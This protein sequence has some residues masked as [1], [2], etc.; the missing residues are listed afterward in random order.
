M[1]DIGHNSFAGDQLRSYI[2][3]IERLGEE[4]KALADDIRE[5]FGEAKATGFDVK[6]IRRIIAIRKQDADQRREEEQILD[7][8]L[9]ALGI[10]NGTPL[11]DAAIRNF[12]DSTISEP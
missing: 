9:R 5:V 12:K 3:R 11:G 2:E 10:L 8:Y 4:K 6:I 1:T 7:T